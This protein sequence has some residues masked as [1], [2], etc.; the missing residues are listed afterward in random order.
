MFCNQ[1]EEVYCT[2]HYVCQYVNSVPTPVLTTCERAGSQ[3]FLLYK[4]CTPPPEQGKRHD[5]TITSSIRIL[6]ITRVH[7]SYLVSNIPNMFGSSL[8]V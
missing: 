8:L 1:Y 3:L 2:K 7:S 6:L 5:S 4:K